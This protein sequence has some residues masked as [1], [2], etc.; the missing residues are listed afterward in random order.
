EDRDEEGCFAHDHLSP[1]YIEKAEDDGGYPYRILEWTGNFCGE[2]YGY[3]QE[4]QML[5]EE[6]RN[7]KDK[8][9]K[10]RW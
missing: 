4:I 3:V 9:A 7:L 8:S 5:L 10:C 1:L 6:Y 2:G